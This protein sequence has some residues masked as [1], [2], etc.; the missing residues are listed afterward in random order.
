MKRLHAL[1][2]ATSLAASASAAA[3][4]VPQSITVEIGTLDL[5]S[6]KGQRILAM[7][8]QRAATAMCQS[9]VVASLP[10][11]IRQERECIRQAKA[12]AEAAVKT[13]TASA[14][15]TSDKGG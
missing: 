6:D 8:I 12:S 4:P 2:A 5:G 10:H 14:A 9:Q 13:L 15:S 3:A 7:R 1:L 11:N